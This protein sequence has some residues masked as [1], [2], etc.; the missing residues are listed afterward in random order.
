MPEARDREQLGDALQQPQNDR[1]WVRDQVCEDHV[2]A[3]ERFGPVWNQANAK[4]AR[5]TR[6]A[7]MP[8][9]T[10]WWL[11]PAWWPGKK[12]GS[13][14]RRLGPVDDRDHDQDDADDD[15]EDREQAIVRH[16]A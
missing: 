3:V 4:Q 8:C 6:K 13:E 16:R 10:W 9:L 7:A 5:P 14:L 12:L 2:S 1:L 11:D 15:G